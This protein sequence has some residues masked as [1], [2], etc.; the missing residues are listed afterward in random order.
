MTF[1]L[2]FIGME[3]GVLLLQLVPMH[4]LSSNSFCLALCLKL[5]YLWLLHRYFLLDFCPP[6]SGFDVHFCTP[7]PTNQTTTPFHDNEITVP[8]TCTYIY[9]WIQISSQNLLF[10]LYYHRNQRVYGFSLCMYSNKCKIK[11]EINL[12]YRFNYFVNT[13][14]WLVTYHVKTRHP[15]RSIKTIPTMTPMAINQVLS[16]WQKNERN[17]GT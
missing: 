1:Y 2:F 10:L 14:T 5:Q 16:R 17:T 3:V 6:S 7:P 12:W 4:D 8:K 9:D 11:L 15:R 13:T